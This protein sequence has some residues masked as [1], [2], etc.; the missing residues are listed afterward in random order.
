MNKQGL[1]FR[2]VAY[3]RHD[4]SSKYSTGYWEIK[5]AVESPHL[6]GSKIRVC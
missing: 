3:S 2:K 5:K 1:F 6:K 4:A